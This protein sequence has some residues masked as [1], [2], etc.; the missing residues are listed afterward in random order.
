MVAGRRTGRSGSRFSSLIFRAFGLALDGALSASRRMSPIGASQGAARRGRAE[1][2][3]PDQRRLRDG[4]SKAEKVA[5]WE[6]AR[7]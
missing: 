5:M 6:G 4:T 1:K 3:G 2:R 7:R